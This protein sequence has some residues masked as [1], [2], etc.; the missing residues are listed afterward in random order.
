MQLEG[1]LKSIE[2][3][4]NNKNKA[5]Q[6]GQLARA[7]TTQPSRSTGYQHVLTL[8]RSAYEVPNSVVA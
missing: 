5:T 4:F 3:D 8:K 1:E 2:S 6:V 7:R